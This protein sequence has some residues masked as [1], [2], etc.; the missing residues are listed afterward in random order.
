MLF[1][2]KATRDYQE[3]EARKKEI[4]QDIASIDKLSASGTGDRE[5]LVAERDM[6]TRQLERLSPSSSVQPYNGHIVTYFWPV[7]YICF[8]CAAF[9]I[10]PFARQQRITDLPT[11]IR[12]TAFLT[13]CIYVSLMWGALVSQLCF[14]KAI[15]RKSRLRVQ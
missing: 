3:Y 15:L 5:K 1:K 14:D 6:Y 10:S 7:A 2:L 13:G 11:T 9:L 8:G 4:E 12:S